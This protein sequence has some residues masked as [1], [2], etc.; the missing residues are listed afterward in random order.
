MNKTTLEQERQGFKQSYRI[1]A[2]KML[3]NKILDDLSRFG[4]LTRYDKIH[5]LKLAKHR[6]NEN[7]KK[8]LKKI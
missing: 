8:E 7:H 1:N 6:V 2:R 3:L 5:V 4:Q